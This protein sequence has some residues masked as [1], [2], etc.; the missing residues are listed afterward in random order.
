MAMLTSNGLDV[1]LVTTLD[2]APGSIIVTMMGDLSFVYEALNL[3]V[4]P[5]AVWGVT[6]TIESTPPGYV[7]DDPL[8]VYNG[9]MRKFD[10]PEGAP[11]LLFRTPELRLFGSGFRGADDNQYIARL[12]LRGASDEPVVEVAIRRNLTFFRRPAKEEEAGDEDGGAFE[13]LDVNMG[14]FDNGAGATLGKMPPPS[15]YAYQYGGMTLAFGRV[16]GQFIGEARKEMLM[17]Y[18][19]SAQIAIIPT[20]AIEYETTQPERAVEYAH[21]DFMVQPRSKDECT[22]I[23]PE[24]WG[25][26][27]ISES[28]A[29]LLSNIL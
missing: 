29:A 22:G 24:L 7:G 10:L 15:A 3:G 27:P 6:P 23:L 19:K 5:L 28:S 20:A 2:F 16:P 14:Y 12:N 17:I 9:V 21:L 1:S 18:G 13:T 26:K 4:E 8:T 25:F 11:L